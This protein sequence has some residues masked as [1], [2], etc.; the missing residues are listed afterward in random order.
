MV[1]RMQI[2]ILGTGAIGSSF[3]YQLARAGHTVTVIARGA[4]LE[5]LQRDG[6]IVLV[7]GER[8][9]VQV[10]AAL[11]EASERRPDGDVHVQHLRGARPAA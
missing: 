8:A 7:S 4:R 9:A 5:Q 1:S 11:D 10:N 3:A 2:A 6:A